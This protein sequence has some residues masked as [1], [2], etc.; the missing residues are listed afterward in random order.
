MAVSVEIPLSIPCFRGKEWRYVKDCLDTGWV[1]SAGKYVER[2]ER[3]ISS[4]TGSKH[5]VATSSGTAALHV[6]LQIAG[7]QPQEEVIVP[8]LTFIAPINAVKYLQAHPVFMDCDKYYNIDISKTIEFILRETKYEKGVSINKRTRRR[9]R[10]VIPVHVLGHAV[11]FQDLADLCRERN[12]K[13]VEDATESLGT[14]YRQ[15]KP[16]GSYTGTIGELGCFSFNG[17]KIVTTGGG[18]MIVTDNADYARRA[19][20][21]IA[22]AKDDHLYYFHDTVGFNYRLSNI[23]AALGVAQ[24][25]GFSEVIRI[26][27]ENY[28]CYQK[29]LRSIDGLQMAPAPPYAENNYWMYAVQVDSQVYGRERDDL[30]RLFTKENIEVRPLWHLNH[31]QKPY[32]YCQSY[33]IDNAY[34]MLAKTLNIPCS[35]HLS[36]SQIAKINGLLKRWKK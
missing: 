30:I 23:Q 6:A 15:G 9:V 32:K 22:Q 29:A 4:L 20:Y 8:T 3:G 31:L 7:V 36:K 35:P 11:D 21:L 24:L 10:A 33:K 16:K 34:S 26:K 14:Y 17:N 18:G 25:E 1:S 2:F 28:E 19:R 13:I 5:A 12:I 27:K